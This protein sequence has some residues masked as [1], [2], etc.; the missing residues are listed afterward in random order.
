MIDSKSA[1]KTRK[2][3]RGSIQLGRQTCRR[4]LSSY[5]QTEGL[6]TPAPGSFE[7]F[8]HLEMC[9]RWAMFGLEVACD[10]EVV[11]LNGTYIVVP[12]I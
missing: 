7:V 2:F 3:V 4:L 6:I 5:G 8:A 12:V 9:T 11:D 1:H 10:I